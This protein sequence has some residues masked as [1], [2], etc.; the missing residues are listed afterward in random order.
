M[1]VYSV[2]L[3]CLSLKRK[4]HWCLCHVSFL[5]VSRLGS[6]YLSGLLYAII[7]SCR[8]L[9]QDSV[10]CVVL[11]IDKPTKRF[12]VGGQTSNPSAIQPPRKIAPSSSSSSSATKI[13]LCKDSSSRISPAAAGH[14]SREPRMA[15]TLHNAKTTSNSAT[16]QRSV[17]H[18]G[19]NMKAGCHSGTP[20]TLVSSH[21]ST[22]TSKSG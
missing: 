21:K 5:F 15:A 12:N 2:W 16:S 8:V 11:C 18:I 19:Q 22:I 6:F 20:L 14:D 4:S 13:P 17:T 7:L 9:Q 10:I 3:V 1:S